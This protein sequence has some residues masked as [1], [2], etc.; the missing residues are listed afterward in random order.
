MNNKLKIGLVL[1]CGVVLG[2][3]G[4]RVFNYGRFD[5]DERYSYH[6]MPDGSMMH[7]MNMD[8]TDSMNG[9]MAGLQGKK[10]DEFDK[11]FLSEMIVHHQGAVEMAKSALANAKHK[12][13]IDLSNA[14]ISAQEKE[15]ASMKGWLLGWYK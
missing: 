15:I 3:F 12:E 13:I 5:S 6:R 4:S 9:M 11:A 10:G 7:N 2:F 14:I 1:L 8:M